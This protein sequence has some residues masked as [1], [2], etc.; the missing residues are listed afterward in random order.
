MKFVFTDRKVEVSDELKSYAQKK[1]EKLDRY[2][3]KDATAHLTFSVQR[4]RHVVEATVNQGGMFFR[5]VENTGDMYASIDGT[6]GMIERQIRKNKTRLEKKLR[7]GAFER[8]VPDLGPAIEEIGKYNI[9]R[10]KRFDVKPMSVEDAI[11]Q[12]ELLGHQ[13]F[14][15]KNYDNNDR[16]AVVYVRN[17]GGYGLIESE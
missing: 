10:R 1:F 5:A 12:M 9:V 16:C 13:F 2:F 7:V 4:G 17:D 8:E 3:N 11:L 6:V 15:F 14:F